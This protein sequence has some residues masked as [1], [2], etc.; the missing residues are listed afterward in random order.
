MTKKLT[1]FLLLLVLVG[2]QSLAQT[3]TP[4]V[5]AGFGAVAV[6]FR[7]ISQYTS[8]TQKREAFK[9][10]GILIGGGLELRQQLYL[11]LSLTPFKGNQLTR[12]T[13]SRENY[14][15]LKGF[16]MPISVHRLISNISKKFY[17]SLGGGINLL[18]A[19]LKQY[20]DKGGNLVSN[21]TFFTPTLAVFTS[22]RWRLYKR[23]Q[24]DIN[25]NASM[26]PRF[27]GTIG[28]ALRY[29][30]SKKEAVTN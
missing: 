9:G 15:E 23:T 25:L 27:A 1:S 16:Q 29:N 4:S 7:E 5:F 11:E 28:F 13:F 10:G 22:F 2:A 3:N 14:F 8:L 26:V 17:M 20:E 6:N 12:V 30:F 24:F 21:T 18:R 19:N